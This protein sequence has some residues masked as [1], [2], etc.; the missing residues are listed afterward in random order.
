MRRK[1]SVSVLVA[2]VSSLRRSCV[3]W[4]VVESWLEGRLWLEARS[5]PNTGRQPQDSARVGRFEHTLGR[6]VTRL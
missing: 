6:V 2:R 3:R 5:S 4:Q 1:S